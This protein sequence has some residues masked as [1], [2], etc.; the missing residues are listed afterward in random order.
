MININFLFID[1]NIIYNK[2]YSIVKKLNN[3]FF[4]IE[5]N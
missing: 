3:F 1:L 5:N 4:L 2:V